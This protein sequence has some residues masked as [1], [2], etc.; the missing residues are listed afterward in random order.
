MGIGKIMAP[1]AE[2]TIDAEWHEF[3]DSLGPAY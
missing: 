2:N 1:T 3:K